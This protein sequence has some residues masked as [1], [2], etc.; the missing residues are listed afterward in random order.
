MKLKD[1]SGY[2]LGTTYHSM[3]ALVQRKLSDK[4]IPLTS[5][6]AKV[7]N[8][9]HHE[10]GI[11]QISIAK[12]LGK[13]KPGVTRLVEGLEKSYMIIRKQDQEDRRN[14]RIFLT[15]DGEMAREQLVPIMKEMQKILYQGISKE[16]LEEFKL[17]VSKM[18]ENL[19]KEL[20]ENV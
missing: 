7:L 15:K 11:N 13:D 10:P 3:L 9:V 19:A 8:L 5:E 18:K 6:Q 14:R 1:L 12:T 17:T 20:G 4:D 16:Q 2:L